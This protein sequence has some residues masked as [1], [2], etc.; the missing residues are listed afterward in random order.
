[1]LQP[2]S[3]LAQLEANTYA[4]TIP[5]HDFEQKKCSIKIESDSKRPRTLKDKNEGKENQNNGHQYFLK[6]ISSHFNLNQEIVPHSTPIRSEAPLPE[7]HLGKD[8]DSPIIL[9]HPVSS[10]E[11]ILGHP[12]SSREN[13]NVSNDLSIKSYRRGKFRQMIL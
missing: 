12:V 2:V 10:R 7:A 11:N 3:D 8:N 13:S 5:L 1:M 4:K 6:R 9:E